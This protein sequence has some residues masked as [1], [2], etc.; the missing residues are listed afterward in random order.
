[1]GSLLA[2]A[3][4]SAGVSASLVWLGARVSLVT[5]ALVQTPERSGWPSAVRGGFHFGAGAGD[6]AGDLAHAHQP[7]QVGEDIG[8]LA[9]RPGGVGAHDGKVGAHVRGEVGL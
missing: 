3:L 4:A 7:R 1:M 6:E 2:S 9:A 8:P 5:E